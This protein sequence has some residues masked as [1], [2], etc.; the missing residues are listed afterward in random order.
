[1]RTCDHQL[2]LKLDLGNQR[3]LPPSLSLDCTSA[4]C[5][6]GCSHLGDTASGEERV[7]EVTWMVSVTAPR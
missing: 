1:M 7:V 5:P 4:H 3:L 6:W 2:T